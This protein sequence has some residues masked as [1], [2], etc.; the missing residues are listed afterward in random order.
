MSFLPLDQMAFRDGPTLDAFGRLRT[1]E[2]VQLF[3]ITQEYTYHPLLW[4]HFTASGGTAVHSSATSSTV[5][6]T[7]SGSSGARALRQTKIYY[8]YVPGKSHLIKLTGTLQKSGSPSGAAFSALGYYDDNNGMFFRSGSSGVQVVVR[9]DTSGVAVDDAVDQADWNLDK[10]DGTGSSGAI[11]DWTKEQ[12]F[13]IDLQWLGVGRARFGVNI[14]GVIIYVHESL[15][16]NLVSSAYTRT[17]CLPLRYEVFNGGGSGS[18][19]SLEALCSSVE[20]EGGEEEPD[21]YPLSYSAYLT[22]MSVSTTM[23]P[24]VT[25]RMRDTFNGL[26]ARGH[27]HTDEFSLLVGSNDVYWEVRYNQTVTLG[28]GGSVTTNLVDSDH[29]QSEFDTYTGS[30]NTVSGGVL[31]YNGFAPSGSGSVKVL[32][33]ASRSDS[34]LIVGRTYDNVRDSLTLS[35]R[36]MSGS[37]TLSFAATLREQY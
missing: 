18:D 5:L 28:G 34:I 21:Y 14:S 11:I 6:R 37:A 12:I 27:V 23:R 31:L 9:S 7:N 20:S 35:A 2:S 22:P 25:R 19:I 17:A 8:R 33:Q 30:S 4:D 13:T 15:H 26:T 3:G 16:A 32:S 1:S 10:C 36:S 24:V 29:S